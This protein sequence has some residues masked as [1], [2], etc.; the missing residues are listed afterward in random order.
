MYNR[1][2]SIPSAFAKINEDIAQMLVL[3][4]PA[5]SMEDF[6][7]QM[8]KPGS[9]IPKDQEKV[10]KELWRAHGMEIVGPPLQF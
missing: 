8:S 7:V 6:F 2:T 4:Q 3:F 5:G 1:L 9:S 10:L